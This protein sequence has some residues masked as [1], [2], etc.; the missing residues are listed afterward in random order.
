MQSAASDLELLEA[1]AR[2]AGALARSLMTKPLE[3]HSKGALGPVTNI[4]Y[5]VD[6]LLAERLLAARPDYGWLS[7]ETPDDPD[8][9]IGKPRTF[10]LDPIDGTSAL[11]GK[12]PQWTICVGLVEGDHAF[13]GAIYNPM[14]DEMFLG[15][16]GHGATLNGK[17][18]R[19]S[20]R[21]KLEG[22]RMIGQPR[23]FQNRRWEKPWPKL[24]IIERQSIAYRMALVAAAHGDATILFGWKHDWDIAAGAAIIQAAGGVVSDPWGFALELNQPV[25][26]VPGV[27]AAGADLHALLIERTAVLPDPRDQDQKP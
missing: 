11:V 14:T 13:A 7:E 21:G 5:A 26:R 10:M 20:E 25:P 24:D 3:V 22:A 1:A 19:T 6:A 23:R 8:R 17:P 16:V 2:E 18:I 9:R 4:D 15:A 27:V 12:V